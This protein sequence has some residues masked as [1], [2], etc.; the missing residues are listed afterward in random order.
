MPTKEEILAML[1]TEEGK[2][3]LSEMGLLTNDD[4]E[5]KFKGLVSK[6]D[7]LLAKIADP[8][9]KEVKR[10]AILFDEIIQSAGGADD[11][12]NGAE[13]LIQMIERAKN[14]DKT[15]EIIEMERE[16]Q[17]TKATLE[18]MADEIAE[19]DNKLQENDNYLKEMM[20]K[21]KTIQLLMNEGCSKTLAEATA[22]YI[23]S[24]AQFDLVTEDGTR[25]AVNMKG[26]SP[27]D[28]FKEWSES[29]ESQDLLPATKI[30]RGANSQGS[31]SNNKA[32]DFKA[33]LDAAQRSGNKG[34]IIRLTREFQE[35][36]K[37]GLR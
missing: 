17:R 32:R 7:E 29:A 11:P 23:L 5:Q 36:Q 19:R 24:K 8:K 34:E 1:E 37:Q 30:N 15:P 14:P 6:K 26:Q 21:N 18:R 31:S 13:T 10:K 9:L 28:Y 12:A 33:E 22:Q 4:V 16:L 3:A 2:Q 20:V 35:A 25:K 27:E